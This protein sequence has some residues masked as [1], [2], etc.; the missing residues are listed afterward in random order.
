MKTKVYALFLIFLEKDKSDEYI[1]KI[2]IY[3]QLRSI[4]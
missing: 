2:A 4:M 3:E 1:Q